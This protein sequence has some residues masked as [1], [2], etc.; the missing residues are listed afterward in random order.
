MLSTYVFTI[1]NRGRYKCKFCDHSTYK[2]QAGILGHITDKHPHQFE[3]AEKDSEIDR[4]KARKPQVEYKERVVYR[5]KEEPKK[6]FWYHGVYCSTC[7][8]V[9]AWAGIPR[10]QTI[11]NT[12]HN[13]CGNKTLM[14]VKEV[15]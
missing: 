2:T 10:G 6:Q 13:V 3:L 5:D 1:N 14:P 15:S 11:Q 8:I 9:Y 4:L 7:Q 12:P